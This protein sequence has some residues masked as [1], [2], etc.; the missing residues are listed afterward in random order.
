MTDAP[1]SDD[2]F[3]HFFAHFWFVVIAGAILGYEAAVALSILFGLAYE[4]L[5][6]RKT[7][8]RI[9]AGWIQKLRGGPLLLGGH[10]KFSGWDVIYNLTGALTPMILGCWPCG[11]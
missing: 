8:I 2:K 9:E 3:S 7:P 6:F 10:G 11:T 5:E 4:M 1:F